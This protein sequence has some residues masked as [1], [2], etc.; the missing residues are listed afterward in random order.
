MTDLLYHYQCS[1]CRQ[2]L[3]AV[4]K[5]VPG[6]PWRCGSCRTPMRF[7]Y[8]QPVETPRER[9]W[10]S[11]GLVLNPGVM[12]CAQCGVKFTNKNRWDPAHLYCTTCLAKAEKEPI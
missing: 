8:E 2:T 5:G 10:F 12:T 9:Q 6:R 7:L 4:A 1:A 3:V 11:Y